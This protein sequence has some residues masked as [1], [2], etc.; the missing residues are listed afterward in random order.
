MLF[1]DISI[2]DENFAVREHMWVGTEGERIA[3][4]G[5]TAPAPE[6]AA[7]FGDVVEGAGRLLMPAMYNAHAHA[8]M[9]LLRGY[10]ENVPLMQWLGDS[11]R[12]SAVY[13]QLLFQQRPWCCLVCAVLHGVR[14]RIYDREHDSADAAGTDD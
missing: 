13:V 9:T 2:I 8:P 1:S 3:Y 4:V 10:A 6:A 7:A 12:G 11:E 14:D 5:N